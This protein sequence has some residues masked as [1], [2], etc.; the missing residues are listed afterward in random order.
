MSD[1][2]EGTHQR[3]TTMSND[4]TYIIRRDRITAVWYRQ[5]I[6]AAWYEDTGD[7]ANLWHAHVLTRDVA[8][9]QDPPPKGESP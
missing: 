1:R 5:Q 9:A 8:L 2:T 3:Y 6:V 7:A 4:K